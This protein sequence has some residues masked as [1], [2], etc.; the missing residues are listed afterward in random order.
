M[1][2]GWRRKDCVQWSPDQ[3]LCWQRSAGRQ[4]RG[5]FERMLMRAYDVGVSDLKYTRDELA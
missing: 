2:F 1:A 4:A 5:D 3:S